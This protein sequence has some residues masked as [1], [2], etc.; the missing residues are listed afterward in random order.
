[1]V[2][3]RIDSEE[4]DSSVVWTVVAVMDLADDEGRLLSRRSSELMTS[5]GTRLAAG[6][7][8]SLDVWNIL[9]HSRF[10]GG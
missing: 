10:A 3:A 6:R 5:R 4:E 8:V 9:V 1:M 7:C 2:L